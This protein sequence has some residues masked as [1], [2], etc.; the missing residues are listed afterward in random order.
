MESRPGAEGQGA[1]R[2]ERSLGA[3]GS[4]WM[5]PPRAL[6]L[7]GPEQ[8]NS[9][10]TRS[11]PGPTDLILA[12]VGIGWRQADASFLGALLRLPAPTLFS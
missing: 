9:G 4:Y 3:Y 5:V 12:W 2:L 1:G 7:G 6:L 11:F 10:N 8:S